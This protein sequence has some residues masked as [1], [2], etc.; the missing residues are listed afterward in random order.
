MDEMDMCFKGHHT[1]KIRMTYK[2][3]GYGLQ[4]DA[5]F[6]KGYTYQ[7]FMFNVPVSKTYLSKSLYTL[8]DRV[9][10][11]LDM[12]EEKNH[13]CAMHNLYNSATFFKAE[14]NH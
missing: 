14:Y 3:E 10:A 6:Q 12:L 5:I 4:T 13:Q 1:G 9:M 2:P 7:I 11:L 8:D